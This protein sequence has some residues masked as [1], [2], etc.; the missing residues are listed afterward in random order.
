MTMHQIFRAHPQA[1]GEGYFEHMAV[2]LGI[3]ARLFRAA[4]AALAHGFVP[5]VCETTA[6]TAILEMT[7][8]I[9][10]R[11]ATMARTA[12]TGTAGAAQS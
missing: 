4:L 10:A 12:G 3:S 5:A 9:R 7:D 6:S 11:R 2:A 8:E 1:V